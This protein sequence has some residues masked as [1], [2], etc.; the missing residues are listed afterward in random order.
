MTKKVGGRLLV[1]IINKKEI[2]FLDKYKK[3]Y[4]FYYKNKIYQNHDELNNK[5]YSELLSY[6]RGKTK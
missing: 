5:I 6:Y 3:K 2:G 1:F 4:K